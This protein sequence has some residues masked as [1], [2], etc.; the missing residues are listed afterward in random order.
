VVCDNALLTGFATEKK[1]IDAPTI[2]EVVDD[3]DGID[4]TPERTEEK[5]TIKVGDRTRSERR[6]RSPLRWAIFV[7]C[8]TL[9]SLLGLFILFPDYL[10]KFW[11]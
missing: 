8:F 3:L 6:T 7:L 5:S 10:A 2:K 1:Q 9:L 4:G 11:P